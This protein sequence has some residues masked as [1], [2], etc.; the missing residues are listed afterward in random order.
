[1]RQRT[2]VLVHNLSLS[3][4]HIRGGHP[5]YTAKIIVNFTIFIQDDSEAVIKFGQIFGGSGGRFA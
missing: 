5:A 4:E 3:I 1:L 2:D